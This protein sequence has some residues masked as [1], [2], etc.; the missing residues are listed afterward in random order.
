VS[1]GGGL[2]VLLCVRPYSGHFHSIVPLAQALV[3]AGHRVLVATAGPLAP[4]VHAAGLAWVPAGLEAGEIHELLDPDPDDPRDDADFGVFAIGS[5]VADLVELMLGAFRP[6]VVLRES[7]DLAATVAADVIGVPWAT[8]GI[9]SFIEPASWELEGVTANLPE[10]RAEWGLD[11]DP[12]LDALYRGVYLA[13]V[14]PAFDVDPLPLP[15]GAVQRVAYR[16]WDGG[17]SVEPPAWLDGLGARPTVLVTLGTVFNARADLFG[18]WIDELVAAGCD[19][20]GTVGADQDPADLGPVPPG[21]HLERYL[22]HSLVLPRTDVMVCHGGFNTV[23]GAL[24]AGVPVVAIPLGSD[25]DHNAE[26]C[27]E[28][29]FGLHVAEADADAPTVAAAVRT[30]LDDGAYRTRVAAFAAELA[31]LPSLADAVRRLEEVA[32]TPARPVWGPLH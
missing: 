30:I 13:V 19:V 27:A 2:R 23:M 25:Q 5:K 32:A 10:V 8:Y 21:V 17:D 24:C 12:G 9:T 16:P 4:T 7:T 1:G 22:P 11:A 15:A 29:G 3:A 31:A 20:V 28:H 14:P 26:R 18:A 6:D